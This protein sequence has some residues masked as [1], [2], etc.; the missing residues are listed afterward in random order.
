MA[1]QMMRERVEGQA[2]EFGFNRALLNS[3]LTES[4]T[5]LALGPVHNTVRA[6]MAPS[7]AGP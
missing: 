1:I 7:A 5:Y 6:C 4:F 2:V 3:E